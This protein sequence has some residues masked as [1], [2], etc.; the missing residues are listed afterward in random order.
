MITPVSSPVRKEFIS[1]LAFNGNIVYQTSLQWL[2]CRPYL[3]A[4]LNRPIDNGYNY[5]VVN[6]QTKLILLLTAILSLYCC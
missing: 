5:T 2:N 1:Y 6:S 3:S 4:W